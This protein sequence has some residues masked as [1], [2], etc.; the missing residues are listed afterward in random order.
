M[1]NIMKKKKTAIIEDLKP[2]DL[3]VAKMVT[4]GAPS[5]DSKSYFA[6]IEESWINLD[7]V[8]MYLEYVEPQ[9]LRNK[10]YGWNAYPIAAFKF[11][12]KD[13]VVYFIH[14]TGS[15]PKPERPDFSSYMLNKFFK[16]M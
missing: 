9:E 5:P 3:F 1:K 8:V 4:V 14:G 12:F 13:R 11:L 7:D 15:T 2:G 16:R 10:V 6:S